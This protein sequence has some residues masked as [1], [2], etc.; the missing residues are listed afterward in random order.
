MASSDVDVYAIAVNEYQKR[1]K[2][3]FSGDFFTDANS[4]RDSTC[5]EVLDSGFHAP[6]DGYFSPNRPGYWGLVIFDPDYRLIGK[7]FSTVESLND[8]LSGWNLM[9]NTPDYSASSAARG[10]LVTKETAAS[11]SSLCTIFHDRYQEWQE[12]KR[13]NVVET[14]KVTF[15]I[16]K[17]S[18]VQM[19]TDEY[20][21]VAVIS[22]HIPSTTPDDVS[23]SFT[24]IGTWDTNSPGPTCRGS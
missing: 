6:C 16:R 3:Y 22:V 7:R 20:E 12:E 1:G 13:S 10:L 14:L 9:E 17:S 21:E 8:Y 11:N 15:S 18:P 19:G 23:F 4:A 2:P 24:R 5:F